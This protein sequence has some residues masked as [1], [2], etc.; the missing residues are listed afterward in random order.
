MDRAVLVTGASGFIGREVVRE[1]VAKG[2]EVVALSSVRTP[3]KDAG[4]AWVKCDLLGDPASWTPLLGLRFDAV[5]HC[6]WYTHHGSFWNAPI[7]DRWREASF[8]FLREL[9]DRG[10]ARVI[11]L[12]TCAEYDWAESGT[13]LWAESRAC[14]PD[15]LYGK[16]KLALCQQLCEEAAR[17]GRSFAWGRLFNVFGPN[18][19]SGKL[20]ASLSRSL[21]RQQRALCSAGDL[22]RDMLEVSDVGRAVVALVDSPL[23]GVVNIGRGSGTRI[24][25]VAHVLGTASGR[26][27]LLDVGGM[28]TRSGEPK[29]MVADTRR[30]ETTGFRP[31]PVAQGLTACFRWWADHLDRD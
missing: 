1:L 31:S 23:T 6:A 16:A 18:E 3:R 29:F 19:P 4:V 14:A 2:R 25:D 10:G 28:S 7:N 26:P 21:L 15:T 11:G 5:I 27:D 8:D 20:V 13:A 30:L 22:T 9:L 24:A 17:K 12:G